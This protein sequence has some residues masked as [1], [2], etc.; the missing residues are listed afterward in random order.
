M[1][2]ERQ[3][4]DALKVIARKYQTPEQLRRSAHSVG[5]T[6]EEHIEMAYENIQGVAERAIRGRRRPKDTSGTDTK[7]ER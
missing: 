6:P 1:S 4:Y 7:A 3:Y 2:R 5:L